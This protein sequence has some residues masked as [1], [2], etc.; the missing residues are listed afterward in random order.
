[1]TP[2][3]QAVRAMTPAFFETP[4]FGAAPFEAERRMLLA[5]LDVLMPE[6]MA[7]ARE[8]GVTGY[9]QTAGTEWPTMNW[10]PPDWPSLR[11][12]ITQETR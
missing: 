4:A 6:V 10:T 11:D 3:E 8:F 1:M 2:L 12:A 5:A 7:R 9:V